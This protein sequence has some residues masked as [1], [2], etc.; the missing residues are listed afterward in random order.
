M[1]KIKT[2]EEEFAHVDP[3]L[4]SYK[5][6]EMAKQDEIIKKVNVLIEFY[7][8]R[9]EERGWQSKKDEA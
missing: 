3:R 9:K 5:S 6:L 7:N 8:Q 4:T 1:E 2:V